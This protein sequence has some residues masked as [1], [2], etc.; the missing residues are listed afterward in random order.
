MHEAGKMF[1]LALKPGTRAEEAIPYLPLC[2]MVL[3]MTVEPGFGGQRFMA[4]MMP[5][6]ERDPRSAGRAG[7]FLSDS[8]RRRNYP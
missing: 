6:V 2:E 4:E 8:G 5:K 7:I 1:A 3:V